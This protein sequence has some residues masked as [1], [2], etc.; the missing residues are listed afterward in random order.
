MR[1]AVVS[2]LKDIA[3]TAIMSC[4]RQS[5]LPNY[6]GLHEIESETIL[7]DNLDRQ[8]DADLFIFATRHQ[9]S[10]GKPSL[11]CH[12]P[13]NWQKAEAGGI[14]RKLCI[15]PALLLKHAFLELSKRA[16]GMPFEVTLECTHHGPFLEKPAMFIEIGSSEA[17]WKDKNAAELIAGIIKEMAKGIDAIMQSNFEIGFGIGGTHY[18]ST[19]NKIVQRTSIA[20]GHICPKHMLEK[21]DR[22]MIEQAMKKTIPEAKFA[23]LDWKGL[24]KEKQRIVDMLNEAG[25]S[26]RRSDKLLR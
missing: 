12:A 14:D 1:I 3:G 18:C 22:S 13:G 7:S 21:L 2:S 19:F 10:S 15:A 26:F 11:S 4:L 8:I 25:I 24:G 20:L 5:A 16:N 9:S 17:Q 6:V 23:V